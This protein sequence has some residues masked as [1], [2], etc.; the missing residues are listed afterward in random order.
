MKPLLPYGRDLLQAQRACQWPH[1]DNGLVCVF[2]GTGAWQRSAAIRRLHITLIL[3]PESRPGDFR[4]PVEGHDCL[5]YGGDAADGVL[6]GLV[7]HL[8]TY[9]A[10]LVVVFATDGQGQVYATYFRG[11]S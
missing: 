6:L 1:S 8:L 9:G 3:P 7:H 10:S 2:A 4:W 5:V 11:E